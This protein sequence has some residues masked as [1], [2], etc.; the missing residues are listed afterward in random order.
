MAI[1]W[2]LTVKSTPKD[3]VWLSIDYK[4]CNEFTYHINNEFAFIKVDCKL[5]CYLIGQI[6]RPPGNN[7][8]VAMERYEN[9]WNKFH[10]MCNN[11][12]IGSDQT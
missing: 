12:V 6:S 4:L 10:D 7:D 2:W 5:S 1:I 11:V 9:V 8:K 3:M